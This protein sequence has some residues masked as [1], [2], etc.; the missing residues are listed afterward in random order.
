M[1]AGHTA[2]ASPDKRCRALFLLRSAQYSSGIRGGIRPYTWSANLGPRDSSVRCTPL[3]AQGARAGATRAQDDAMRGRR[4]TPWLLGTKVGETSHG[5][6]NRRGRPGADW[7]AR[8][9]SG[10]GKWRAGAALALGSLDGLSERDSS[11]AGQ[12]SR[13]DPP[14]RVLSCASVRCLHACQGEAVP[15]SVQ[16]ELP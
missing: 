4:F 13:R 10:G 1:T 15:L 12:E 2:T 11:P 3:P 8:G 14:P 5:S 6:D 9:W 16:Q 7:N